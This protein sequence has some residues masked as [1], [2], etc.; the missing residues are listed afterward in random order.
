MS[1]VSDALA[2]DILDN[3]LDEFE[4]DLDED[5]QDGVQAAI[6]ESAAAGVLTDAAGGGAAGAGGEGN[7][8]IAA[9]MSALMD[10]MKNPEFASTL[11]DTFK[12]LAAGGPA[13]SGANP[14]AGVG[15]AGAGNTPMD[16]SVANTLKMLAE[17]GKDLEG[18]DSAAAEAMGEEMMNQMMKE[19]E[20]LGEK[21]DFQDIM[22]GMMRQLLSRD[23]M[24]DPMK[25]ITAKFPEWLA[26][27]EDS[28]PPEDYERYGRMYQYFQ[29]IV[30][31]YESEPN[32]HQRLM[33]L[34][35]D[36]QECG[37]PPAEIVKE[38]A[39]G[40]EFGP[41]G[42]PIM[43]NM[44]SGVPMPPIPGMPPFPGLAGQQNCA[45]C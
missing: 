6:Q 22:D 42:M 13:G 43:T 34:M 14:F 11:E 5:E 15:A 10:E 41:D 37:Q 31:V 28:L 9:A 40:L 39:P 2:D 3:A 20:K 32:N 23:V 4:D 7:E 27:H 30:A 16:A 35:Q 21:E 19:F 29:K 45:I 33:E 36:M 1:A 25:Q 12:Q 24:Y 18:T 17:T 44:G 38:L 26:E 8:D